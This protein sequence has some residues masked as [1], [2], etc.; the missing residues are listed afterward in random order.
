[1]SYLVV[2]RR[3]GPAAPSQ[4]LFPSVSDMSRVFSVTVVAA[5]FAC[6]PA[7]IG[8]QP[9]RTLS[10]PQFEYAEPFSGISGLRELRDGRVVVADTRDKTLQAIDLRTGRATAI[11]REGS[12]PN[13]WG[14][15]MR[16]LP[17]VG[18]SLL[19]VDP[20]NSRF[21]LVSPEGRPVRTIQPAGAAGGP[22]VISGAAGA[23]ARGGAGAGTAAAVRS[24]VATALGGGALSLVNA[25]AVDRQG[26]LY[27]EGSPIAMGPNG[28]TTADSVPILRQTLAGGTA[29]TMAW[30][31]LPKNAASVQSS[32]GSGNQQTMT[33][34]IGGNTP[35]VNGDQWS[36]APDGRIVIA[37][38]ADYHVDI[39]MPDKRVV[40]GAPV[41]Y[42]PVRVTDADKER[43]RDNQRNT[44]AVMMSN[45]NGVVSRSVAAAAAAAPEPTW[46][47]TKS[48]FGTGSVWV[49]PNGQVWVQR[50]TPAAERAP[51]FDVFDAQGKHSGQV[52]LPPRTRLLAFG[53]KGL[54]LARNDDDD[55]QY[56][57]HHAMTW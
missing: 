9:L 28:P 10:T 34:R 4:T 16:V 24:G 35:F 38:V 43:W 21:L 52:K 3:H 2:T 26:R 29:D 23:A 42:T 46:P 13:E 19:V 12:G 25:R 11:G 6:A 54:Y 53:A 57:Q 27:T 51:L 45:T 14:M 22:V 36:V 18:D 7:V 37:R 44:Q 1:M 20:V 49:A 41:P 50:Q 56:I 8:A 32:G 40:R 31:H 48:P 17:Y 39:V 55:L 15:P 5:A 47:A 33:V 30:I